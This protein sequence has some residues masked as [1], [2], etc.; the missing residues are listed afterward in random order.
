MLRNLAAIP[1][2]LTRCLS[3]TPSAVQAH[4]PTVFVNTAIRAVLTRT[5]VFL[6]PATNHVAYP[7]SEGVSE[8]LF[9]RVRVTVG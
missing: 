1:A 3:A 6:T 5:K 9:F 7:Y 8:S 2:T 4:H